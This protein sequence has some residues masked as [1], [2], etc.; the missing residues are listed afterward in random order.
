MLPRTLAYLDAAARHGSIR[1]AARALN[2]ASSAVNRQILMLEE[3]LGAP[4]F[5]RLP[6]GIRPTAAG[7]LLLAQVRRWRREE[8]RLLHELGSLRDGLRGTVRIAAAE[9]VCETILPGALRALSGRYPGL[10]YDVVSGDNARLTATLSARDA[11]LVVAFDLIE[12]ERAEV[13]QTIATPMGLLVPAGHRLAGRREVGPPDYAEEAFVLPGEAW[14]R[15]SSLRVLLDGR[16]GAVR[17]VARA[18]RPG[19]LR[20]MVR[21][22]IG[23]AFLTRLGA[24]H[25]PEG[26]L[27]WVPL[28]PGLA[29]PALVALMAPRGRTLPLGAAVLADILKA[30][31]AEAV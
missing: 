31:M 12:H 29:E 9:S 6:R 30:R 25:G 7:E 5:E 22:G 8:E 18:E 4:L 15:A 17:A 11:D 19:I 27:A 14:L 10:D 23:I 3:E 24:V 16:H 1:G 13:L 20:A 21:A 28:A 2:V 26:G